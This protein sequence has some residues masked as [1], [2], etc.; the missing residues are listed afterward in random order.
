LTPTMI[1]ILMRSLICFSCSGYM[2]KVTAWFRN[3]KHVTDIV[4]IFNILKVYQYFPIYRQWVLLIKFEH[5]ITVITLCRR[6]WCQ[7]QI[8]LSWPCLQVF[9]DC[10]SFSVI[11]QPRFTIFWSTHYG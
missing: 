1:S 9:C 8:S 2:R 4:N 11:I 10:F 7:G 6:L 5:F 3:I